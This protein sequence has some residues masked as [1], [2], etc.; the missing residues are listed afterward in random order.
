MWF[1]TPLFWWCL[2][3]CFHAWL[4]SAV[5]VCVAGLIGLMPFR[6]APLFAFLM[7]RAA[8]VWLAS[9]IAITIAGIAMV[10]TREY[11]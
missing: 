6:F 3:A 11:L 1:D 9:S 8:E 5:T 10:F 2:R 4:G 7:E